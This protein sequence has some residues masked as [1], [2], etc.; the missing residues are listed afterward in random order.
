MVEFGFGEGMDEGLQE[1]VAVVVVVVV[2]VVVEE[3]TEIV[4]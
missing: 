3:S 4:W 2:V 1:L